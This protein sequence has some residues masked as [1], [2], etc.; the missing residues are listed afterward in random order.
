MSERD[1]DDDPQLDSLR[2]VW[3][4]MPEADPPERGL[5]ELMAAARAKADELAK[6]S[7]WQRVVAVMKRPPVLAMA[8]ILLLI[9]GGIVISRGRDQLA[10]ERPPRAATTEHA[11]VTDRRAETKPEPPV[12]PGF[13]SASAVDSTQV[14]VTSP[15]VVKSPPSHRH[16]PKSPPAQHVAHEEPPV[17]RTK[18]EGR[19]GDDAVGEGGEQPASVGGTATGTAPEAQQQALEVK[20]SPSQL[21]VRCRAAAARRDCPAAKAIAREISDRDA[22]FYRRNVANDVEIK[23]CL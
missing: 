4:S 17:D 18:A 13:G 9:G 23:P 1:D 16:V 5:G 15:P 8:T 20:V 6:P 2:A 21:L 3:R 19:A 22:A 12:A 11:Q 10:T 7:W 14:V